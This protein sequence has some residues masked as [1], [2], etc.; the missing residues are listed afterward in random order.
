MAGDA[1]VILAVRPASVPQSLGGR[2]E[3]VERDFIPGWVFP[4][5]SVPVFC[6]P[7][8]GR[9]KRSGTPAKLTVTIDGPTKAVLFHA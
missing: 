3:A 1:E 9:T 7:H 4:V 6:G 5:S 2:P 8:G